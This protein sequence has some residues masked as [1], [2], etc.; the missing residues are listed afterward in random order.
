[1]IKGLFET[2]LNVT[3]LQRSHHFYEKVLG[4]PLAS[5]NPERKYLFYWIGGERHAM[6]GLWEKEPAQVQRQHFAFQVSLEDMQ[7]AVEYLE[8][9][10][11]A[12][13]NFLDDDIGEL[14]VFGWMP[15]V[16]VYFADPDGHSLEFIALLPDEAKPEL[17]LV[18]WSEWEKM[19]GRS[20]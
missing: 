15:A 13:R 1:M 8:N 7:H 5:E 18:P 16:A 9:K 3:D 10:G 11:I 6:L 4:L 12:T 19:H 14:Y 2:H 20:I 17:G